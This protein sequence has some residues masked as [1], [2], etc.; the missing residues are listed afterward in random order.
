[1]QEENRRLQEALM[2]GGPTQKQG[3]EQDDE[4]LK[5]ELGDKY[6]E[7]GGMMN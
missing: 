6:D 7:L 5:N 1:M 4:E 2:R 3:V